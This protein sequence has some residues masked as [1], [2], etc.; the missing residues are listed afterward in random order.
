MEGLFGPPSPI[1]NRI[2]S[3][4]Y[5][6]GDDYGVNEDETWMHVDWNYTTDY[7]IFGHEVKSTERSPPDNLIRWII[8]RCSGVGKKSIEKISR[9]VRA[10]VCLVLTSQVQVRSSIVGNS[11][12]ATDAQQV[13]KSAFK[14]LINE[15]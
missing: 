15:E 7:G 11:A 4:H 2:K 9:S 5:S 3:A 13:F 8:T 10:Y 14:A 1:L 12:P 6:V